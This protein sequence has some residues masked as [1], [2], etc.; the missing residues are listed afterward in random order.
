MCVGANA[1]ASSAECKHLGTVLVESKAALVGDDSAAR[2]L[3]SATA[4]N[5][6][7]LLATAAALAL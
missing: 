5:T 1:D 6:G 3:S 4:V 2:T 7:V